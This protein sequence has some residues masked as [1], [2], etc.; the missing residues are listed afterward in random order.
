M[1]KISR[2]QGITSLN[3][4]EEEEATVI[5]SLTLEQYQEIC[6]LNLSRTRTLN[7]SADVTVNLGGVFACS[8][9]YQYKDC[10]EI[11]SLPDVEIYWRDWNRAR[12]EVTQNGWTR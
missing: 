7:I 12:G 4:T 6:L 3:A 2:P 1:D 9:E 8:S 5:K 11:A 10:V